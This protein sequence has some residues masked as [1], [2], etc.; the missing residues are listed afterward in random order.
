MADLEPPA[1]CKKGSRRVR[2]PFGVRVPVPLGLPL[3]EADGSPGILTGGDP[4]AV[5]VPHP[6]F[7]E[8]DG[9]VVGVC[10]QAIERASPAGN[11]YRAY[12]VQDIRFLL[13]HK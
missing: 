11:T 9:E 2:P 3:V 6:E 7:F 8:F 13:R 4:V 10:A 12:L 1:P 5:R